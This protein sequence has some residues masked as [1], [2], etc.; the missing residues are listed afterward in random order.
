MAF[1]VLGGVPRLILYD[2]MT[3]A[4]APMSYGQKLTGR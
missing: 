4:L 1:A 2:N 3:L